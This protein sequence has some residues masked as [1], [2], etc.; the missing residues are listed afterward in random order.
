M[1]NEIWWQSEAYWVAIGSLS[2]FGVV[3]A[4]LIHIAKRRGYLE[5]YTA[6]A[7]VL[8]TAVTIVQ[9]IIAMVAGAVLAVEQVIPVL[10]SLFFAFA[11]SGVPMIVG[12]MADHLE[13]R[14]LEQAAL[15]DKPDA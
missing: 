3:Y 12:D 10:A 15:R 13:A 6:L 1:E 7:V 5:G 9:A 14:R 2:V 11:A 8:G 4:Y